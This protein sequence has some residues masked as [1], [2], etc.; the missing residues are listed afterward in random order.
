MNKVA[1]SKG[2]TIVEL[3]IVVVVIAILAAITIVAYNGI[4]NRTRDA[5]AK[6]GVATLGKKL[7]VYAEEN[8]TALP[9]DLAAIGVTDSS[10]VTYQYTLNT[11]VSPNLYCLTTTS[12]NYTYHIASGGSQ[13][14]GPCLGH[15][16]TQVA[17]L[18]CPSG[19]VT[20][21][22]S[23]LFGTQA[24]CAMKYEAKDSSG[25]AVS[26]AAGT[27]WVSLNQDQSR[28]AAATACS[29]CKLMSLGQWL[30]IA[31]NV[32]TVPSNWTG[33]AVG[34]GLLMRGHSDGVPGNT[35]A[36][37]VDS[38]AYSG[39]GNS[40]GVD[41]DQRRTLTLTNGEVIW[42]ISG[43]AWEVLTDATSGAA[44]AQPG[45]PTDTV[46]AFVYKQWTAPG[47]TKGAYP[48]TFPAY[49]NPA[50]ASWNSAQALGQLITSSAQAD[51]RVFSMGAA[52]TT[53]PQ[54]SGVFTLR[55]NYRPEQA[56]TSISFRS[57][58]AP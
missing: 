10:S 21:P 8:A 26:T 16:G 45:L 2:F 11:A 47:I 40:A 52:F 51:V 6:Q 13:T 7:H 53:G 27:P 24:F 22:G 3:L 44:G 38:N 23:S 5:A 19:F 29:G 34:S 46:D 12:G 32:A 25:T 35:I 17:N 18:D 56:S 57:V 42:D 1:T 33:G 15:T 9:A 54:N 28:T 55:L 36:A 31:H 14:A 39:T 37:D 4:Q 30:T 50:A 58:Y 48:Q 41:P 49:G 20:I 43:N